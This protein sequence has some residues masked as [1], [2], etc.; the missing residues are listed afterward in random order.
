MELTGV[1]KCLKVEANGKVDRLALLQLGPKDN[2]AA[3]TEKYICTGDLLYRFAPSQKTIYVH[4]LGGGVSDDSFLD[5][6]FQFKA[7]A[8]KKRYEITLVMPDDPN[9]IYF[10]LKPRLEADKTE[11][12]RPVSCCYRQN[13]LPAQ[14][15]FEEPNGNHRTWK[16]SQVTANDPAV[17]PTDF[18]APRSRP[19]GRSRRPGPPKPRPARVSSDPQGSDLLGARLRVR[20]ACGFAG[21]AEPQAASLFSGAAC[22]RGP[23]TGLVPSFDRGTQPITYLRRLDDAIVQTGSRVGGHRAARQSPALAQP[24]RGPFGG[25]MGGS[26]AGLLR[27]EKVQK[28][29]GVDKDQ[30]EKGPGSALKK[31]REDNKDDYEKGGFRSTASDEEKA[32]ARKKIAAVET[33]AV[34][35]VLN[36]KQQ[37]RLVQIQ[38]QLQGIAM[39]ENAEIQKTLSLSDDQKDKIKEIQKDLSKETESLTPPRAGHQAGLLQVPGE[40][41]ED[42]VAP[43]GST[44]QCDQDP[45]FRPEEATQGTDGGAV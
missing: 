44:G 11:F 6:L 39:F 28:E 29:L 41:E 27:I 45:Q 4:K 30:A 16:L 37:K 13:Y 18:V 33:K 5:F 22:N 19:A 15:W 43:Q 17:K 38:H 2:P 26:P 34:N 3:F 42:G 32:A 10:D 8:M 24:G 36:E 23:A 21:R 31:A 35:G 25:G 1:V 7:D 14:L 9:Y 40:H 12:Q 20:A